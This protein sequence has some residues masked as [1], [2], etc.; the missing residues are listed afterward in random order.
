MPVD[1]TRLLQRVPF[2]CG[3]CL[4]YVLMAA[5]FRQGYQLQLVSQDGAGLLEFMLVVCSKNKSFH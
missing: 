4:G 2:Q 3:L 1:V 5:D